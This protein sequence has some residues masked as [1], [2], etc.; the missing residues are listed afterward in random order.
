MKLKNKLFSI[1]LTTVTTTFP[2]L[3]TISCKNTYL[4]ENINKIIEPNRN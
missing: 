4:Q 3:I 2:L 1:L